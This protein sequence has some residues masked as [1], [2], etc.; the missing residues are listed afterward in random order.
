MLL[1]WVAQIEN[2]SMIP[3]GSM[4]NAAPDSV[5]D[6]DLLAVAESELMSYFQKSFSPRGQAN[7]N[8]IQKRMS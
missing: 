3:E 8:H 5:F 1:N 7:D 2:I 6:S 4:V